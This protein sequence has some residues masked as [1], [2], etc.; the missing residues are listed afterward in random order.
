MYTIMYNCIIISFL[1]STIL[2]LSSQEYFISY[3]VIYGLQLFYTR[4]ICVVE[5]SQT[6]LAKPLG[7][8]LQGN[9]FLKPIGVTALSLSEIALLTSPWATMQTLHTAFLRCSPPSFGPLYTKLPWC[10]P[11]LALCVCNVTPS[12][13][14]C[15]EGLLTDCVPLVFSAIKY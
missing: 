8:E 14:P 2:P 12:W 7:S 15:W 3:I 9:V 6:G 1:Y 11:L 5:Y 4:R 10:N 13:S